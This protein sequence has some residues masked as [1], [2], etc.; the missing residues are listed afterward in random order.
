MYIDLSLYAGVCG[1]RREFSSDRENSRVARTRAY[2]H[3]NYIPRVHQVCSFVMKRVSRGLEKCCSSQ[4]IRRREARMPLSM[5]SLSSYVY[6]FF[7]ADFY[8]L[9]LSFF[10]SGGEQI[11]QRNFKIFILPV[12]V[13]RLINIHIYPRVYVIIADYLTRKKSC[14]FIFCA[15]TSFRKHPKQFHSFLFKFNNTDNTETSH[16]R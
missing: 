11:N 8:S 9:C 5:K 7:C 4:F 13:R 10:I 12:C 2:I 3:K 16:S 1:S 15:Y 6:V 14:T